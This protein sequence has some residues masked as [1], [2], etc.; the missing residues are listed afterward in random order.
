MDIRVNGGIH[1]GYDVDSTWIQGSG[2]RPS[3]QVQDR[4]SGTVQDRASGTVQEKASGEVQELAFGT[5]QE[6]ASGEVQELASGNVQE[7]GFGTVQKE[8]S[9]DVQDTSF[10]KSEKVAIFSQKYSESR[11]IVDFERFP[12]SPKLEILKFRKS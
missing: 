11:K 12:V 8:A 3:G 10:P 4:A 1:V 2:P 9:G 6:K 7:L 5:V